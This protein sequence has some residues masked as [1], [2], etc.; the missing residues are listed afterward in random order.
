MMPLSASEAF[1]AHRPQIVCAHGRATHTA[2]RKSPQDCP[3]DRPATATL[4]Q[5]ARIVRITRREPAIRTSNPAENRVGAIGEGEICIAE[6]EFRV[7]EG[8]FRIAEGELAVAE[9]E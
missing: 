5:F 1:S 6:G 2:L 8:E 4:N 3:E 7:I 9:A